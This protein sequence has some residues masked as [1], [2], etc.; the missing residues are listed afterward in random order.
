[1]DTTDQK[2]DTILIIDDDLTAMQPV[3]SFLK[4]A[5]FDVM[6]VADGA[7]AV[8]C[9]KNHKVNLILLDKLLGQEDGVVLSKT[10]QQHSQA[11]IL[12]LTGVTEDIE[13]VIAL[14]TGIDMYLTKPFNPRVLLAYIR[15][16]LRMDTAVITPEPC[17]SAAIEYEQITYHFG[18]WILNVTRHTLSTT[19]GSA[20]SLTAGEYALLVALITHPNRVLSRNQLLDITQRDDDSFDR[21]VDILISRLRRK[22]GHPDWL[23]TVRNEGYL[24]S[25]PVHKR[26]EKING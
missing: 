4:Q 9:L 12:M 5:Y 14:E 1:M 22:L 19:T 21:S 24:L 3:Q 23:K 18:D 26:T 17:T 8:S 16:M 15:A 20:V 10:L 13:E 7:S 25:L 11:P 2:R 6:L